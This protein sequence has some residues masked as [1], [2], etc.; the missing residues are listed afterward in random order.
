MISLHGLRYAMKAKSDSYKLINRMTQRNKMI[1][2]VSAQCFMCIY[3]CMSCIYQR[4]SITQ[5]ALSKI[6][7]SS[8]GFFKERN[9]LD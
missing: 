3:L 2:D 1:S 7:T 9:S 4:L 6:R 8:A 5:I